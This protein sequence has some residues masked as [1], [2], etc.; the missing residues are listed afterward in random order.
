MAVSAHN[1]V[2]NSSSHHGGPSA[3]GYANSSRFW[4]KEKMLRGEPFN[5]FTDNILM[6]ER[7]QCKAALE[8]YN[9][10]A[11]TYSHISPE[12]R[13]RLF[14]A[15]MEPETRPAYS[16]GS[17]TLLPVPPGPRGSVGQQV[18][19]ETPFNCDYGYNIHLG[20]NVLIEAGCY[21]QDACEIIIGDRTI[22]GPNVKFYGLTAEVD[23]NVRKG[24]QGNLRGGAIKIG[25]DCFIGGDVTI[26]P[27]RKIGKGAVV[28]ASS[29]VTKVSLA[30]MMYA[31]NVTWD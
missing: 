3:I 17:N 15:I 23:A 21:L 22:V 9:D 27:F 8:R 28:G 10:A 30:H 24:S 18:V 14:R 26:L 4:E 16:V 5:H 7:R 1:S 11:R 20:D 6:H 2:S 12:E 13:G 19:V 29:V 31:K 25:E